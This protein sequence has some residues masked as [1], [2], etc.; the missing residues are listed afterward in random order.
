[1]SYI[2]ISSDYKIVKHIILDS[3]HQDRLNGSHFIFL[4]LIFV[5]II[6]NVIKSLNCDNSTYNKNKNMKWLSLDASQ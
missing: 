4:E 6:L 3:A 5:K 1:M 2:L